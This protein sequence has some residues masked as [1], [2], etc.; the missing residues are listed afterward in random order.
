MTK[1]KNK[2]PEHF[3]INCCMTALETIPGNSGIKIF[4]HEG[5]DSDPRGMHMRKGAKKNTQPN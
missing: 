1:S 4:V 2:G 5:S 3:W